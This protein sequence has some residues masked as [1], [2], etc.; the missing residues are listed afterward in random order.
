[1]TILKFED[2]RKGMEFIFRPDVGMYIGKIDEPIIHAVYS[3]EARRKELSDQVVVILEV[4]PKKR[5]VNGNI[6]EYAVKSTGE[7]YASFWSEFKK[8]SEYIPET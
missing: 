7:V 4:V 2:V 1:M 5:G 3:A 8:K 6:V